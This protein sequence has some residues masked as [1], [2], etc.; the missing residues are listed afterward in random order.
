MIRLRRTDLPPAVAAHLKT[1]TREIEKAAAS[2]RKVKAAN[3][4]AHSTVRRHV[5]EGLLATLAEMAPGHQRCMYCGDSQGTDIDHF[6]PK[7]LAPLR[8]FE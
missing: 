2:K 5:R 7:S 8:T 3:L 4:W 6:E 1:Y